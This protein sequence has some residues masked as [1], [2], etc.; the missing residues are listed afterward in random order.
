M[1]VA[2]AAAATGVEATSITLPAHQSGDFIEQAPA[3][4]LGHLSIYLPIGRG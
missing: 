4:F 3:L 2:L 1:V